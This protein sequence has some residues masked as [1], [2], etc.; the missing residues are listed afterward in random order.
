MNE[1][2]Q[3]VLFCENMS[4]NQSIHAVINED[5]SELQ[6][7]KFT[8]PELDIGCGCKRHKGPIVHAN[9]ALSKHFASKS[10]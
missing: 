10:K 2:K 9:W 8:H 3:L 1:I 4:P 5:R 6:C 7:T